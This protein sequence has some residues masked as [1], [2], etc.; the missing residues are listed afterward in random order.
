MSLTSPSNIPPFIASPPS[1]L[2]IKSYNSVGGSGVSSAFLHLPNNTQVGLVMSPRGLL[3]EVPAD[4]WAEL[5][6]AVSDAKRLIVE[7]N[8]GG[9][10]SRPQYESC[11]TDVGYDLGPAETKKD[12]IELTLTGHEVDGDE[13]DSVVRYVNGTETTELEVPPEFEKM[14]SLVTSLSAE[15]LPRHSDHSRACPDPPH[16]EMFSDLAAPID[17]DLKK[18]VESV[19][20]LAIFGSEFLW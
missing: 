9:T 5:V 17:D 13:P 15:F 8:R 14:E 18:L 16:F 4:R 19:E 6:R 7:E 1:V 10:W 11:P 3:G 20:K 2:V 12:L